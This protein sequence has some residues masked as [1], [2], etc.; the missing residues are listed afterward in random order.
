M[1]FYG[2]EA[3]N[4]FPNTSQKIYYFPNFLNE[5]NNGN[6]G[7]LPKQFEQQNSKYIMQDINSASQNFLLIDKNS[8]SS[9]CIG[10]MLCLE[11]VLCLTN[12]KFSSR[13]LLAFYFCWRQNYLKLFQVYEINYFPKLYL[14]INNSYF[15][16]EK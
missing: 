3:I 5:I 7:K 1:A 8:S 13:A 14:R 2:R 4:N 16:D 10:V 12:E 15:R 11:C 9:R 6:N